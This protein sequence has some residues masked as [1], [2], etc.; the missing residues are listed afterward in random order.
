MNLLN[1]LLTPQAYRQS[2]S[3]YTDGAIWTDN[4]PGRPE[5]GQAFT[6]LAA[7]SRDKTGRIC[8]WWKRQAGPMTNNEAEYAAAIMALEALKEL[9]VREID[10]FTDSLVMVEQMQ[11]RAR[12]N[13]ANLRPMHARLRSLASQFRRVTFHHIPRQANQLADALADEALNGV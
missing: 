5:N 9:G 6:G 12:V 7:I 11:G 2:M 4:K 8:H 1:L 3:V 13:A 10:V